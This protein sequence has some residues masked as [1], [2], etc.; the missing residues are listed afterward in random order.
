MQYILIIWG[1]DTLSKNN[2]SNL[3]IEQLYKKPRDYCLK[4]K[5]VIMN[6]L[7]AIFN[8]R[9]VSD[10]ISKGDLISICDL[11]ARIA[12]VEMDKPNSLGTVEYER[13]NMIAIAKFLKLIGR[14]K[15]RGFYE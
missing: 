4:D 11:L 2:Y 10:D 12:Y 5:S 13:G 9:E 15:M 8:C 7:Q 6:N 3:F 1:G 14:D